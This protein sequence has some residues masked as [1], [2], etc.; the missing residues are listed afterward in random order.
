MYTGVFNFWK[1]KYC[2]YVN[3]GYQD[4]TIVYCLSCLWRMKIESFAILKAKLTCYQYCI[5]KL[6]ET[7]CWEVSNIVLAYFNLFRPRL[8]F[9][10]YRCSVFLW[11]HRWPCPC[12]SAVSGFSD[13]KEET[14]QWRWSVH[15]TPVH[16]NPSL[17][18]FCP[19]TNIN[20]TFWILHYLTIIHCKTT[21]MWKSNFEKSA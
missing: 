10:Q 1:V 3:K 18:L 4:W 8:R 19:I 11:H 6:W 9:W 7:K 12:L 21:K 14:S 2:S 5:L 15:P 13:T 20:A 16:N 17:P